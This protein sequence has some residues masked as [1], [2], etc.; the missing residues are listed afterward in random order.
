MAT[1]TTKDDNKTVDENALDHTTSYNDGEVLTEEIDEAYLRASKTTKFYRGVLFQMIMFG[2]LSFVGPAMNDAISNLGGGGLSTPYLGNLATSL[3][4]ISGC[5]ITLFGGPLINKIGIKWSCVISGVAMPLLGSGWY[6]SAKY[7]VDWYLLLAKVI[8]GFSLGFLYVAES[9]AMLSY[10]KANDRGFYLGIWSAMRNSGSVMGGAINFSNNHSKANAGGIALSTYLI[11]VAFECTSP[12]WALL[13]TPTRRVR[14]PD[15]TK[16]P[17]SEKSTWKHEFNAL[18]KHMQRPKTWLMFVPAF[19]SF[20]YGGSMGTYLNLH[21]SVRARALSSMVMPCLVIVMVIAYG[22]LLDTAHWSQKKRAWIAFAFWA[23][24]QA[25]CF[26]WIGIEY[27]K[28]GG[29]ATDALDYKLHTKRWVEAYL[30]YLIMFSTGYWCQLSIYW[31]LGTFSTD[32]GSSSRTGGLFRA[33]ETAGQAVSY[34]INSKTGSDARIPFYVNAGLLLLTIP[35]M[36]FLI[37][38]VPEAPAS[39]DIDVEPVTHG[40]Q[41]SDNK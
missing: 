34:A 3:N 1:T 37:R 12:F 27:S 25:A 39:T 41:D 29:G 8:T 21:F 11:F 16:I 9:T 18:W 26:I 4:Y 6:V 30:P 10:P 38:L 31:I 23:I 28:F 13:L 36:V 5:L 32:V 20:F 35:S 24:P 17:M 14:R 22:K 33:F 15:G 7:G 2:T 40:V 19:Y